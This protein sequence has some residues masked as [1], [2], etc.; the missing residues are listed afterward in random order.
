M[1]DMSV[2]SV[3]L[4]QG[5][6][7]RLSCC[8]STNF[9][10]FRCCYCYYWN[11]ARKQRPV[12]PRLVAGAPAAA[13]SSESSGSDVSAPASVPGSRRPSVSNK[14]PEE[15]EEKPLTEAASPVH[16]EEESLVES[17]IEVNNSPVS[18]VIKIK[19]EMVPKEVTPEQNITERLPQS[20]SEIESN[21]AEEATSTT[22]NDHDPAIEAKSKK[23]YENVMDI[24]S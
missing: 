21:N 12:A 13:P 16:A 7:K 18:Q 9:S 20:D 22:N 1:N 14:E 5:L 23:N 4:S 3:C 24:D 19:S 8:Y 17:D 11:P 2:V 15:Q 10:L 6:E